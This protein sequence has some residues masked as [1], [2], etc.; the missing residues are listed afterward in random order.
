MAS[1]SSEVL[2]IILIISI[3]LVVVVFFLASKKRSYEV[4]L[5]SFT[6]DIP[7]DA[8]DMIETVSQ[9][10]KPLAESESRFIVT[11]HGQK[12]DLSELE[13]N[14]AR[15]YKLREKL[16]KKHDTG[17]VSGI[18][19]KNMLKRYADKIITLEKLINATREEE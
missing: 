18:T 11:K 19:Y 3:I 2:Y 17:K 8:L 15:L 16:I 13:L 14:L 5:S 1:I 12:L 9:D 6:E 7:L 4:D 10:K